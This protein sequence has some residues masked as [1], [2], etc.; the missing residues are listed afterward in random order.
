MTKQ[1]ILIV[2]DDADVRTMLAGALREAGYAIDE[3]ANGRDAL[4]LAAARD[5]VLI[6]LD[7]GL[8]DVDGL[9]LIEP[10]RAAGS[11][12]IVVVSARHQEA[13]KVAALDRGADDY[14]SKPFGVPELLAR[15]RA[16][17]RRLRPEASAAAGPVRFGDLSVDLGARTVL[18]GGKPVHLTPTEFKLLATLI[19]NAGRVMTHA[20]LLKQAWGTAY[21]G[22][23]H[24]VRL[25]MANLRHKLEESPTQP[26]HFITET[27]VGY[28]LSLGGQSAS[29]SNTS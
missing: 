16:H 26:R 22:R 28:R 9:A 14:L 19:A 20:E 29:E 12:S 18:R 10:L 7:L 5:P 23:A 13:E 21:Q 27:G 4:R 6:L 2:E 3:A 17:I 1:A 24:Y 8:P 11:A 15:V 25:H